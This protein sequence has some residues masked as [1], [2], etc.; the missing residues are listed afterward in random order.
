VQFIKENKLF[1]ILGAIA[2]AIA[3]YCYSTSYVSG[4][5]DNAILK[6]DSLVYFSFTQEQKNDLEAYFGLKNR[7]QGFNGVVLIGQKDSVF[8]SN[9]YGYANY[10][11]RDSLS[12]N[13]TFQLASV[14]KQFTAVAILQLFERGKLNLTDSV[15]KYYP[16]FPFKNITIHQLL[17]HRSGLA[18]YLY[19]LQHIPTT[20]DTIIDNQDVVN[21]IIL[22]EPKS[23]YRADQRY[24]YSNTG[25]ALLAAIVEKVSGQLFNEYLRTNIFEPLDM[26]T[27][28]SFVD[29]AKGERENSTTGYLYR[30]RMAE[31]NYLDGVLGDKGVYCSAI[32]LFKWD[33]GLYS[34]KI[35]D[36]QILDMAFQP[37]G[38]PIHYKSNYGY[39]WRM[40]HWQT[41]SIKILF[42]AGWWHGYKT[43]LMR[44]PHDSTTIVVLKNRSKGASI[45]SK[46][47]LN[48]LYPPNEVPEDTVTLNEEELELE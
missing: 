7:H 34:G 1:L 23:Y 44:I 48:I 39:G 28:F 2:Y 43:L 5:T 15:S 17:C 6:N 19:F 35:I 30:W 24:H 26:Q 12:L 11:K 36:L 47:L 31:D 10:Q 9:P 46:R 18:N 22:K 4:N 14:S 25:Y 29:M 3:F 13:S 37:V 45:S 32:D 27:S 20:Y 16:Q 40:Y 8:Y 21:E 33:Q 41:D 38:K 42:H